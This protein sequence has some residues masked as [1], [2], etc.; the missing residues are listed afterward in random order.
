M[1]SAGLNIAALAKRTGVAADTLRKWEQRYKI[2]SPKRT[3]GGQRRYS[4]VDVARVEW[5]VERLGEGYRIGEAA[6]LLGGTAG[7]TSRTPQEHREAL[8]AAAAAAD[9]ETVA[10]LL[11]QAFALHS[12]DETLTSVVEPLLR[13]IGEEW[14]AGN[15][16]VAQEHLVSEAVRARIERL[17]ADARGGVRGLA[18]L[19]CP[20][21][22]R[23]D[24][25]L[26]MLAVML[27]AD[28]WQV[29]YLGADTPLED[30]FDLAERLDARV[31]CLSVTM[32][33]TMATLKP[34][35]GR[36]DKLEVVVGGTAATATAL[37]STGARY[38]NSN[39]S[40]A[41]RE[42]RALTP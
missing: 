29:A 13:R 34:A 38:L 5:L 24:C 36:R 27:R 39:L 21:G 25:G 26:L 37:E 41:V 9:P 40:S 12:L 15:F 8:L 7:E 3:T 22:E 19:A 16:T 32:P 42:L 30:A 28:G 11:D 17:L 4:E 18:V 1:S 20:P 35:L 2:L 31:L 6:T 23:H 33:E 10:R 14:K